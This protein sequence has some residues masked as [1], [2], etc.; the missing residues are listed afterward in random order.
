VGV[1]LLQFVPVDPDAP[2]AKQWILDELSG[3]DYQRAKP[4]PIDQLAQNFLDWIS[5]LQFDGDGGPPTALLVVGLVV[6]IAAAIVA[7][8]IFGLPR[9]NRRS[10]A[11]ASLFGDDDARTAA[12]IRKDAE[13]AA[14][15]HDYTLAIAEMFRAI[16]RGLSERTVL[17]VSPGTTAHDF[18]LRAG[19]AFPGFSARL[20]TA[21]RAFDDVRYLDKT[22]TRDQYDE[23]AALEL[24]L[25]S[26]KPRFELTP[27]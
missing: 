17:T 14:A 13:R 1:T 16:A 19:T 21:A 10:A 27:A 24:D 26:A 4:N 18:G 2:E 25:R 7:F 8:L 15:T 9:L 20:T 3:T 22:G 5:S 11:S 23:I 6:I 12:Q